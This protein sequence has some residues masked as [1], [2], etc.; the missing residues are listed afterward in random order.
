MITLVFKSLAIG[1]H[2]EKNPVKLIQNT[3]LFGKR[4]SRMDYTGPHARTLRITGQYYWNLYLPPFPSP[5]FDHILRKEV[6]RLHG[7]S[8]SPLCLGIVAMTNKCSL[9]CAHCFEGE[10]INRQDKLSLQ[11]LRAIVGELKSQQAGVIILS[12]G[13]PLNRYKDL[14]QLLLGFRGQA[15]DFWINTSGQGLR[16]EKAHDLK[17]AGLKGIIFSLDHFVPELHDEFRG[18]EG[19]FRQVVT[20]IDH[21]RQAGLVTALS[22]V[23]TAEFVSRSN[24]HQYMEMA[25]QLGVA[26]VQ[27]LE[28][29]SMGRFAGGGHHLSEK[30]IGILEEFFEQFRKPA[31]RQYPILSYP[32]GISRKFG[33][34]GGIRYVYYDAEGGKHPCPFCRGEDGRCRMGYT[35]GSFQK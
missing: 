13:E 19:A 33:C 6:G 12:G 27:L 1:F 23:A 2:F 22:L 26:F 7:Q 25:R 9:H 14:L 4:R 5:A 28:P 10:S 15:I 17:E 8:N 31:F 11:D 34:Q 18:K 32:D 20:G 29:K 3:L 16:A 35:F 21:A 24:L 30:S